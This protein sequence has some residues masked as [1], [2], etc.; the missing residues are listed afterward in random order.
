MS[1]IQWVED[2]DKLPSPRSLIDPDP[3]FPGLLAV[4][5]SLSPDRLVEAYQQGMFPW[6]SQNEPVLWWCTHPRM[7][8]ETKSFKVSHSLR[9]SIQSILDNDDWEIRVDHSFDQTI[10]SCANKQR[11]GQNGTWIT[12]E[13]INAYGK[14]HQ[15]GYAHSIE[16]WYQ[17]QLVGGLYCVNI[18]RMVYGESMFTNLTNASKYALA[19]L[20]AWCSSME[21]KY[22]DCQQETKHLA[23]LGAR[24]IARDDFLDWV[25]SQIDLPTPNWKFNKAILQYWL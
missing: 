14:L 7:V 21:I 3:R 10:K 8:L 19:A 4:S 16:T 23:S 5:E 9:K 15:M 17:D 25:E 18:G 11:P 13:I 6:Y 20:S 24:P 22:I 2:Q 12:E 1:K